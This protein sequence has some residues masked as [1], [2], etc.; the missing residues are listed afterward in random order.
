MT[1]E[2]LLTLEDEWELVWRR[3]VNFAT[4]IFVANRAILV[5]TFIDLFMEVAGPAVSFSWFLARVD[6]DR[7]FQDVS[8]LVSVIAL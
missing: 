1:Y 4:L 8:S 6:A 2:C 5:V 3:K 7:S